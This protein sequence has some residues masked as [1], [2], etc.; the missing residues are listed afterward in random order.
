MP[1]SLRCMYVLPNHDSRFEESSGC[2]RADRHT[3]EHLDLLK[4]GDA[5]L[6]SYVTSCDFCEDLH[7]ECVEYDLI[8]REQASAFLAQHDKLELPK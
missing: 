1:E 2:V 7:C 5:A 8:T 6:W 3:G 4:D